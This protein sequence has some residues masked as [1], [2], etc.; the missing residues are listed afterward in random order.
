MDPLWIFI[1]FLFGFAV[2]QVGLPPLIG[3]LAAGFVLNIFGVEGGETLDRIA[4]FGVL[5]LL[6]S[7]GLKLNIKS[8]L[9]PVVVFGAG[10]FALSLTGLSLFAGLSLSTSFLIAFALSFSSTVFAVKILEETT[11]TLGPGSDC[12]AA[13]TAADQKVP[14]ISDYKQIRPW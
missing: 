14:F 9:R 11:L 4:D 1:A 7:I 6:F 8:L 2:K 12:S 10:F 13:F 3:F 5:L